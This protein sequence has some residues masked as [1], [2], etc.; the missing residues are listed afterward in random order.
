MTAPFCPPDDRLDAY[1]DGLLPLAEAQA[2]EAHAHAC[3]ACAAELTLASRI[4]TTLRTE[5]AEPCP[6]AVFD[7]ARARIAAFQQDRPAQSSAHHR[8][9]LWRGV[10][11][12][13]LVLF[14]L[15]LGAVVMQL[16]PAEA[17]YS[18]QDIETARQEVELALALVG[19]A[20]REAGLRIQQDVIGQ[21]VM[22]PLQRQFRADS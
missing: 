7:G 10:T 17:E 16:G 4:R 6:D 15:A 2:F 5:P 22:A 20:S 14:A 19:D 13:A 9:P 12:M 8:R 1:L 11:A 3:P 18:A 21:S